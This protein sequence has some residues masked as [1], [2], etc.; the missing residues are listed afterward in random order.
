ML[1]LFCIKWQEY[2]IAWAQFF[3]I[4]SSCSKLPEKKMQDFKICESSL[5]PRIWLGICT[6]SILQCYWESLI[7]MAVFGL[8]WSPLKG[9]LYIPEYRTLKNSNILRGK[10]VRKKFCC[11]QCICSTWQFFEVLKLKK[12]PSLTEL[13][14]ISRNV[15]LW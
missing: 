4:I 14:F 2:K 11:L 6:P 12:L 9:E 13:L 5:I 3:V 8:Y 15:Y 7:V 10:N 1:P